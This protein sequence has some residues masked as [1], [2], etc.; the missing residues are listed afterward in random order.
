MQKTI[1]TLTLII[2]LIA[3]SACHNVPLW[4][5]DMF[6]RPPGNKEYPKKYIMGWQDGCE[7]GAKTSA[8]HIYRIAYDL[9]H[10]WKLALDQEYATGWDQA[11]N[12][13]RKYVLQHNA[14]T[15]KKGR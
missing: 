5:Y 14:K 8:N 4:K 13:C 15:Y 1:K 6:D 9:R 10:N 2:T 7:S 12:E 3:I 11:F